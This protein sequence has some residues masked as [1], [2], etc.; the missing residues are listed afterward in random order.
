MA[1]HQHAL[2]QGD[3]LATLERFR[4]PDGPARGPHTGL[5]VAKH[6]RGLGGEQRRQVSGL[7]GEGVGGPGVDVERPDGPVANQQR[8][9]HD[10]VDTQGSGFGCERR[11]SGLGVQRFGGESSSQGGGVNARSL[12]G[13]VLIGVHGQDGLVAGCHRRQAV[14]ATQ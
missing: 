13:G 14:M 3:H 12:P 2:G 1:F 5:R 10:G 9:R 8:R 6:R 11:P 4:E 7:A